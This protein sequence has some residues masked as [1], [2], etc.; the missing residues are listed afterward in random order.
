MSKVLVAMSGGVDSSVAACLLKEEGYECIGATIKTWPNEECER[1][2]EKMCC[3]ID[4][5][6]S[7]RDTADRIGIPHYVFD[8]SKVFN[9]TIRDYFESEYENGRTPNPCVYCN[10]EIKFGLLLKKAEE[11]S[12]D[13]ICSGHYARVVLDKRAGLYTLKKGKDQKKDQSYFLFNLTQ[14]QLSKMILPL[15]ELTK[16]KVSSYARKLGLKASDRPSSQDLCFL[17]KPRMQKR[18]KILFT[19]GT[20]LG[21]HKGISGYTVGQRK[22]LGI[23]FKEPLYVTKL[24][25]NN[26]AV[27]VGVKKD[28]LRKSLV[29]EKMNWLLNM[30]FPFSCTAKIRYGQTEAKAVVDRFSEDKILVTFV[31][32]Q[33]A[34]TP[35]QAVVL[36]EGDTVAGGGWIGDSFE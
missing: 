12:C 5:I 24:D 14:A 31:K 18:G 16:T 6:A 23:A 11:L 22:G 10:S 8:F 35:G 36:Y 25:V 30:K 3:S 27:H 15:G 28:T 32:P 20:I 33:N 21:E 7:A 2:G 4:A 29:A 17:R 34:P 9:D 19:D 13:K 26:A 1:T